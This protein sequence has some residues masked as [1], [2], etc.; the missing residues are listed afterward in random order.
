MTRATSKR[1]KR[2]SSRGPFGGEK[3][4]LEEEAER[5]KRKH[6]RKFAFLVPVVRRGNTIG[7]R[8]FPPGRYLYHEDLPQ[9]PA[10][11]CLVL[12]T[13]KIPRRKY[14]IPEEDFG[15]L[16]EPELRAKIL[17]HSFWR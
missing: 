7:P 6:G 9:I 8:G 11:W 12:A 15:R 10:G 1:P 5:L 17:A 14:V 4:G 16:G 13:R 3:T 2:S